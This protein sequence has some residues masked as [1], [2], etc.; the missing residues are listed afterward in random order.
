[1][2]QIDKQHT[3]PVR[4]ELLLICHKHRL[5]TDISEVVDDRLGLVLFRDCMSAIVNF[6]TGEM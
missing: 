6:A 3:A 4:T 1:M 2:L 5:L